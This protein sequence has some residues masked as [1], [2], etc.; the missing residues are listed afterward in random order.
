MIPHHFNLSTSASPFLKSMVSPY[1]EHII[2]K[3]MI[4]HTF[5]F[6]HLLVIGYGNKGFVQSLMKPLL[7]KWKAEL[8]LIGSLN[9]KENKAKLTLAKQTRNRHTNTTTTDY[10]A[11]FNELKQGP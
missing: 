7:N 2:G 9:S 1:L 3:I 11:L 8:G 4:E 10:F 6:F 5:Q